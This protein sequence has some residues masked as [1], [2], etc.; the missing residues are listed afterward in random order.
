MSVQR[1]CEYQAME[2]EIHWRS[3]KDKVKKWQ[4]SKI[5]KLWKQDICKLLGKEICKIEIKKKK[6]K[7]TTK[8]H[9]P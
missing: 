5:L 6:K 4:L 9:I 7:L 3:G 8:Q 1:G 2:N